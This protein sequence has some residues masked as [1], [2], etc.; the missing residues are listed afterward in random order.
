MG[1]CSAHDREASAGL[2]NDPR[3]NVKHTGHLSGTPGCFLDR[4]LHG[5]DGAHGSRSVIGG[6]TKCAHSLGLGH[7][8]RVVTLPLPLQ[9]V[10]ALPTLHTQLLPERYTVDSV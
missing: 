7:F 2:V 10:G 1:Q 5:K 4:P 8:S 3:E 6:E 9:V